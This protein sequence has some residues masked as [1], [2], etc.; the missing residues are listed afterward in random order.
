MANLTF[1][2]NVGKVAEDVLVNLGGPAAAVAFGPAVGAL[3]STAI[4]SIVTV[5]Q[6]LPTASGPEKKAVVMNALETVAPQVQAVLSAMGTTVKDQ[7]KFADGADQMVEALLNM[8]KATGTVKPV[9][10]IA[11]QTLAP[12][13]PADT[14]SG[15]GYVVSPNSVVMTKNVDKAIM[16]YVRGVDPPANAN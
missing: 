11:E 4:H 8:L 1:L 14:T 10:G 16:V 15:G 6:T 5:Q 7:P 13:L 2:K 3:V 12:N 9:A